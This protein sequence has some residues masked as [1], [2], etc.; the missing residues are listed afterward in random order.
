MTHGPR[1]LRVHALLEEAEVVGA[2][3]RI[4]GRQGVELLA[5]PPLQGPFPREAQDDPAPEA[6]PIPLAELDRA[7]DGEA[8]VVGAVGGA[9]VLQH[10]APAALDD[11]RVAARDALEDDL[12]V[13]VL[14][15]PEHVATMVQV[16][17]G[18]QA[19]PLEHGQRASDVR[20]LVLVRGE[21]GGLIPLGLL[22]GERGFGH[23]SAILP[24]D[25]RFDQ[26]VLDGWP[27]GG[28]RPG[29]ACGTTPARAA[30]AGGALV[31]APSHPEP[32][33]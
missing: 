28:D 22:V 6:D 8:S 4:P 3:Q 18:P 33:C 20:L 5:E 2:R 19:R 12:H 10:V 7:R 9:E 13:R 14:A 16:V 27:G 11:L 24:Q 15:A 23:P 32:P 25:S 26:D 17:H 29:A 30:K 1:P 31:G 21:R